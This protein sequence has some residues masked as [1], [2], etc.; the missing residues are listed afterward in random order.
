M[1]RIVLAALFALS[2]LQGAVLHASAG[3]RSAALGRSGWEAIQAGKAEEAARA[4]SEAIAAN[5][6]DATLYLGAGLAAHLQ[7]QEQEAQ[8]FLRE[9]LRRNPRLTAASLLL[10]EIAYRAGEL[11]TAI[12]TYEEAIAVTP[13]Q[14]QIKSRLESWRKEATLHDRFQRTLNPHFTVLFEGPAEQQAAAAA[15]DILE[16]AYWRIGTTLLAYPAGVL[17]VVLYTDEQFR[18]ITR[19]PAWAGGVFDGRI[20]VPMRNALSDPKQLEKVLAHEFTHALVRS[21]APRGVPT[22]LDEGLAVTFEQGDMSWAEREVR[23]A[24]ALLPLP[25][26][27]R[28]FLSLPPEQVPLAYAE[29]VL[30]VKWLLERAGMPAITAFLQDLADGR[31]FAEAFERRFFLPYADFQGTWRQ[32]A[33]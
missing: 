21:V 18:D 20:R 32:P 33:R 4:F 17:T 24:P 9:A 26:L 11:E 19:S 29:S 14:A 6:D 30:A 7:G 23:K 25:Q 1:A 12:K 16:A 27:H 22:W 3:S 2:L 28:G 10:G 8:T 5:S 31:E 15:L 13:D